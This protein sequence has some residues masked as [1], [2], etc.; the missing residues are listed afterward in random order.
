ML[1]PPGVG[2]GPCCQVERKPCGPPG[3]LHSHQVLR[4]TPRST[5]GPLPG[6]E[7]SLGTK[8]EGGAEAPLRAPPDSHRVSVC[9]SRAHPP[10]RLRPEQPA[11]GAPAG[12]SWPCS[13]D[14]LAMETSASALA[15]PGIPRC[16]P[17]GPGSAPWRGAAR[18][19]QPCVLGCCVGSPDSA[20][21]W[22]SGS[23]PADVSS[24]S[25]GGCRPC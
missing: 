13:P 16:A 7:V 15:V 19:A 23:S 1:W 9:G 8:A 14:L 6:A 4:V 25:E 5:R 17:L 2:W 3:A 22:P 21:G 24:S 20:P 18:A 10:P 12:Q 11:P